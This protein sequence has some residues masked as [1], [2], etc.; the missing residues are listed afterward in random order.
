MARAFD[1]KLILENG[2]EFAGYGFG[3]VC[4]RICEIVFNTSMVGYQEII[5]DPSHAAQIVCMTYPV[6]GSYGVNDEDDESRN[7]TIGGLVVR[8]YNDVP[9]NFRYTKTLSEA[10]EEDGIP[11]IYGVDTRAIARIIGREGTMRAMLTSADTA[12]EDALA[13]IAAWTPNRK[14]AESVSCKKR[15]YSRTPNPKYN[16]VAVDCGIK[17][18][19]VR[20]FNAHGCNVTVVPIGTTEAE[21]LALKPDG[22]YISNGP[23]AAEDVPGVI[24]LIR[25]FRG[26]LPIFGAGLGHE[27]IALTCG[28]R[29]FKMKAGHQGGNHPVRNLDTGKIEINAQSHGYCVDP[30]SFTGTGLRMTHQNV[31]DG[32][33]EA[34]ES[35]EYP[36]F[37]SQFNPGAE[38]ELYDRFIR[39]MEEGRKRNA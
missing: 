12:K 23:G 31:L 16:V 32:T 30:E 21:I 28:A 24:A 20:A 29:V 7:P 5:S 36:M 18:S 25:A 2:A 39:M 22:L 34:M 37:S 10:M 13:A 17:L 33:L 1:R 11:G 6:I 26:R 38:H 35:T 9:S 27:L 3:A 15:W 14:I 8:D 19:S 4:E